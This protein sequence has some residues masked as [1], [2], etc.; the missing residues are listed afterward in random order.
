MGYDVSGITLAFPASFGAGFASDME[1]STMIHNAS[2]S[3]VIVFGVAMALT[4]APATLGASALSPKAMG[5][6]AARGAASATESGPGLRF[7]HV[8]TDADT[9]GHSTLIQHPFMW[10]EGPDDMPF[11]TQNVNPYG[12]P[13]MYNPHSVATWFDV[14]SDWWTVVNQDWTTMPFDAGFNVLIPS[15]NIVSFFHEATPANMF[16]GSTRLDHPLANGNPN[17]VVL[18]SQNLYPHGAAVVNDHPPGVWY[19]QASASWAIF[20][21]DLANVPEGALFNV[22]IAAGDARGF[23]H[24]ATAAN[25]GRHATS[26]D[27]PLA[28]DNPNAIL[29]V[30]QNR[31]PGGGWPG[32]VNNH[33]VGVMYLEVTGRWAI[34]NLDGANMPVGAAFNVVIPHTPTEFLVHEATEANTIWHTTYMDHQLT[35]N[36]PKT[37]TFVTPNW[38]PPGMTGIYNNHSIG[39]RHSASKWAIFNEDEE[40]I[41]EGAAFNVLIPDADAGVFPHWATTYN[42]DGTS[43]YLDHP[44]TNGKPDAIVFVAQNLNLGGWSDGPKNDPAIAVWYNDGEE[45]WAIFNQGF[46]GDMPESA[47]FNVLVP[48]S[49]PHVFV[50]EVTAAN[51]SQNWT[52]IDHP[53]VND[54]PGAILLVTQNYNPGGG[55]GDYNDHPLGVYYIAGSG[56]WAIF[57]QD[58]EAMEPGPSFNVMVGSRRLRLYLP[59][60]LR[61]R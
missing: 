59:V 46:I 53:L 11:V 30:T 9:G 60:I 49:G 52:T 8:A 24:K 16:S 3:L 36:S 13:D 37:Y 5:P 43:T 20:N 42:I 38:N 26:I 7:V 2:R 34:V 23:V 1:G 31:N 45:K 57:N 4:V 22:L 48:A 55:S 21:E 58:E 39:V 25:T 40:A 6:S 19:D 61:S 18:V 47:G 10:P 33:D 15:A 12:G 27:H 14:G 50:H 29:F 41:T 32:M 35:N 56:R 54:R 28:N 17:A 44:L 51:T